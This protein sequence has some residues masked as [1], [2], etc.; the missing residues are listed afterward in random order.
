METKI[1]KFKKIVV[2]DSV[3]FYPEHKKI[4]KSIAE[5]ICEYPSSL[6]ENPE[7]QY[8]EN[9]ELFKE[10]KCYTQ[11]VADNIPLQLLMNR[12]E[13]TDVI[14]SCWTNIPDKILEL[15]LQLKLIIFWTHE[16]EHRLNMDLANK[17]GINIC[18]IS[19]YGTDSVAE[20]VFAGLFELIKRNFST[21]RAK[22]S[23][24]I[25]QEVFRSLFGR[26]RKYLKNEK[27]TRRGQFLH[28]FHKLGMVNFDIK[29]D[30][31][32]Y[33]IPEKLIE[34]KSMGI[35]GN[36]KAFNLIK[37]IAERSFAI[38]VK[39]IH[40]INLEKADSYKFLSDNETILI[41]SLELDQK[42]FELLKKLCSNKII[43]INEIEGSNYNLNN[44]VLGI[45]GLGRIGT[46]VARTAKPLGLKI[47]YYSKTRKKDLE[48]EIGIKY[49]D[50]DDLLKS[51]DIISIHL[52]AH[53]ADGLISKKK[54]DLIKGGALL[55]NTTDGNIVD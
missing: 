19:D 39:K 23:W 32:D 41:N 12:V 26:Y 46:K 43:D 48:K 36:S 20:L 45:I 8:I 16:K 7:K 33:I 29:A 21:Q 49:A 34:N 2:L 54:L 3:I 44:K 31:L 28:H 37:K 35:I 17:L 15:N 24:E 40:A 52:P 4:L 27:E 30:N 14:I 1:K 47:V 55:I 13:G 25:S 51:S 42:E 5:E 38:K 9:P 22:H 18:N 53:K 11:I 50:L 6:P 10:K